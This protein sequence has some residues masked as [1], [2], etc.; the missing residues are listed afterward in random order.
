MAKHWHISLP[1][2]IILE[3]KPTLI[4]AF[5]K[6]YKSDFVFEKAL[7]YQHITPITSGHSLTFKRRDLFYRLSSELLKDE[8]LV[9]YR[10]LLHEFRK[11][12]EENA[13]KMFSHVFE[14][15]LLEDFLREME[16]LNCRGFEV[17][18]IDKIHHL[19]SNYF[20][21]FDTIH[22]QT[23][24]EGYPLL[25]QYNSKMEVVCL[26]HSYE[27]MGV[28]EEEFLAF[29]QFTEH[30]KQKAKGK[31]RLAEYLFTSGY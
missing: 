26:I 29:H 1:Y 4:A 16:D 23:V 14:S 31:F 17:G 12:Y 19:P 20:L 25:P 28:S 27:E 10:F 18:C 21:H 13:R 15:D 9:F 7:E 11:M 22:S 8:F 30:I 24:A 2:S 3:D 5:E 6:R